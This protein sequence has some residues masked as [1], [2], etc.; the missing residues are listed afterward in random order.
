MEWPFVHR[1]QFFCGSLRCFSLLHPLALF[2]TKYQLTFE[3]V[4]FLFSPVLLSDFVLSFFTCNDILSLSLTVVTNNS[5]IL[6]SR[7]N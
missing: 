6:F 2:F 3:A 4:S 7:I 5:A 1:F